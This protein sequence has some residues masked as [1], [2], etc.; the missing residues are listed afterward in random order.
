MYGCS[1]CSKYPAENITGTTISGKTIFGG[2]ISIGNGNFT[3]SSSGI[4]TAQG[5]TIHGTIYADKIYT[6]TGE[7]GGTFNFDPPSTYYQSIITS[8]S[9]KNGVV[10]SA[11]SST[12]PSLIKTVYTTTSTSLS[13]KI[14]TGI[15]T[16]DGIVKSV[17]SRDT[18]TD[19]S[20]TNHPI[21]G[22]TVSDGIV[23]SLTSQS[24]ATT[25][26]SNLPVTSIRVD[27]GIVTSLDHPYSVKSGTLS[28]KDYNGTSHS[29]TVDKGIITAMS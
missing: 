27:N 9:V 1:L 20:V 26:V 28:F 15:V 2:S 4:L 18:G 25:L 22:I 7:L 13:N 6:S 10:V 24:G 23:T 21:T 16:V 8:L 14:L 19:Q 3:V 29:I 5:A 17:T 11:G 12:L